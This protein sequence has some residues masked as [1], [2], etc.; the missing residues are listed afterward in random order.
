MFYRT[1]ATLMACARRIHFFG[2]QRVQP[3]RRL[4]H[5][6]DDDLAV[7]AGLETARCWLEGNFSIN[8][9]TTGA[10]ANDGAA[11]RRPEGLG[12]Q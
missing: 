3:V 8:G 2:H 10:F 1:D 7:E 11:L 5:P 4:G 6:R 12:K 9:I